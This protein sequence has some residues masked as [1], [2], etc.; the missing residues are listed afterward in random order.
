MIVQVVLLGISIHGATATEIEAH[1]G[2]RTGPKSIAFPT[3]QGDLNTPMD[4]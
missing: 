2:E 4:H 3:A 1:I